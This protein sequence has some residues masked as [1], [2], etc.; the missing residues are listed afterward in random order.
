MNSN[1]PNLILMIRPKHFGFNEQTAGS[2]SF[3]HQS[4]DDVSIIAQQE[5]DGMVEVLR[6]KEID[7]KVFEDQEI[8]LPDSV[9]P[10]N[11]ISNF[12]KEALVIYPMLTPNRRDEVREDVIEW[13]LQALMLDEFID[14]TMAQ[15]EDRILEGTG[16]VVFDHASKTAFASV[17]PRTDL[18]LLKDLCDNMGYETVSFEAV[19][20]N[21]DQIYHT[22]VVMSIGSQVTIICLESIP[23]LLER[24]MVKRSLEKIGKEIIEIT[25]NQMNQFAGNAYEV[26]NKQGKHFYAMSSTAYNA[27]NEV[28]KA[29]VS[30]SME[31]LSIS[32]PTI[33]KVGGGSVRCMMAGLFNYPK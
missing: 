21:G 31:I 14:L 15:E 8:V 12:P 11:W 10:N 18:S 32:I 4:S 33:E 6:S 3:Q 26:I 13:A 25:Y 7:V 28:Q 19:D 20:L 30:S 24:A 16:S 2:N 22:N 17:S 5:F 1:I 23:D 9:F 27:L 29:V